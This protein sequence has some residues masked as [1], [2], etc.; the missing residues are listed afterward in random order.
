MHLLFGH[1]ADRWNVVRLL[2]RNVS[3]MCTFVIGLR[4]VYIRLRALH[5]AVALHSA[6]AP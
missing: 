6:V 3:E 2:S 5:Y 1:C 4:S